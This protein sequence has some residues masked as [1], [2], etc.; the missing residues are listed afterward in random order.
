MKK[1]KTKT[2]ITIALNLK[3]KE[4]LLENIENSSKYIEYL[5]IKD[6]IENNVM[7]KKE[8]NMS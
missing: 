2:N 1:I 3:V 5:I 4:Y 7:D 6:L 8:L